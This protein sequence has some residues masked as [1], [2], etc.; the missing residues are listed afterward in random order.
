MKVYKKHSSGQT[1]WLLI[2]TLIFGWAAFEFLGG[3]Y[4]EDGVIF[5]LFAA[6]M[7]IG[8]VLG[9]IRGHDKM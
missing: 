5:G 9:L 1:G 6:V 3:N 8:G 4:G 7:T 2:G